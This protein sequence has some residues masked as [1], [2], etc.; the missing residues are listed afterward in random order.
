MADAAV[1]SYQ[2]N[3]MRGA[4][5]EKYDFHGGNPSS[6]ACLLSASESRSLMQI[7]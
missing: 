6:I 4:R 7:Q 1:A 3:A 2:G 5:A